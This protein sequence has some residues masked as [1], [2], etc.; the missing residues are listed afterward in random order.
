MCNRT[1]NRNIW[2]YAVFHEKPFD[3]SV[4]EAYLDFLPLKR[5]EKALRY[6]NP[7]DRHHCILSYLLLRHA[8]KTRFG[9]H[10][11][12][13]AVTERGKPFLPDHP[14][15]HFNISHCP[16]G[17]VVGVSDIPIGVDVQDIRAFSPRLVQFCC[18]P[19]EQ[20]RIAQ[21]TQPEAEF[22]KIWAMKES[23]LKCS[24]RG[25]IRDLPAVDT[26]QLEA[27]IAVY[28]QHDCYIAVACKP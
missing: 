5:R 21:T 8:L 9:L 27:Q 20:A 3:A 24:G 6:R 2:L 10:N 14:E 28:R 25:I 22:T 13:I 7:T 4:M 19:E 26:T 11:P 15:V 18:S 17:C 12:R 23:Y 16:K 1:Q